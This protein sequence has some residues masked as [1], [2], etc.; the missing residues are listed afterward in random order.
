MKRYQVR[1]CFDENY[2]TL[3]EFQFET[4]ETAESFFEKAVK[5]AE[6]KGYGRIALFVN[7]VWLEKSATVK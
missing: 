6:Q 3:K 5:R 7:N 2:K 1:V 4:K